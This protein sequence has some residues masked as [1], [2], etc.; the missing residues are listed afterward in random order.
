MSL[1]T[2]LGDMCTAATIGDLEGLETGMALGLS[3]N[4]ID[5]RGF[6]PFHYAC[7]NGHEVVVEQ[8]LAKAADMSEMGVYTPLGLS[9][10]GGH[11]S[12]VELLLEH[13][14]DVN[15]IDDQSKTAVHIASRLV[16]V[17]AVDVCACVCTPNTL[18]ST[19]NTQHPNTPTP[20]HPTPDTPTPNTRHPTPT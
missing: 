12:I 5:E 17:R 7:K 11:H 2:N 8:C 13:G 9:V 10:M 20:Q 16:S 15:G 19:P 3:V 18:R 1:C 4:M 6:S 14:C